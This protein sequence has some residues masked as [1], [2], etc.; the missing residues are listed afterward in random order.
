V[1]RWL[2]VFIKRWMKQSRIMGT[3]SLN[4]RSVPGHPKTVYIEE[5]VASRDLGLRRWFCVDFWVVG[6]EFG[7]VV[8][9]DLFAEGVGWCDKHVFE[10]TWLSGRDVCEPATHCEDCLVDFEISQGG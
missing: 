10:K 4:C 2:G 9:V 6:E 7:Q 5:T 3:E 8:L 1:E